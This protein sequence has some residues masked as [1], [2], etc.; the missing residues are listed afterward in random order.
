MSAP[1][2]T[3]LE[4]MHDLIARLVELTRRPMQDGR[5]AGHH[6]VP[7]ERAQVETLA[8]LEVKLAADMDRA[9]QYRKGTGR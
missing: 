8:A 7:I 5:L 4:A 1:R 9:A 2:P 3:S 6:A